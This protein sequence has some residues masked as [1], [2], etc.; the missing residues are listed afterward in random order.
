MTDLAFQRIL[1]LAVLVGD[2]LIILGAMCVAVIMVAETW[3]HWR[4][5]RQR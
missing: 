1:L 2:G 4:A 3:R 5:R